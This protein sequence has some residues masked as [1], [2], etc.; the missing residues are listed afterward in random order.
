LCVFLLGWVGNE[1]TDIPALVI[2]AAGLVAMIGLQV[3]KRRK[4]K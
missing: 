4:T 1:L 2:V 3:A